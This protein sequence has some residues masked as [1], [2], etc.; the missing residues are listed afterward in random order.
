[1]IKENEDVVIETFLSVL[2]KYGFEKSK[3]VN[4]MTRIPKK[5]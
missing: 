5:K 2:P 3:D 1:L 4:I